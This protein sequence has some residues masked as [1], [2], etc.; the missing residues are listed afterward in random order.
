[1]KSWLKYILTLCVL[2][3]A[4]SGARASTNDISTVFHSYRNAL[5]GTN[6]VAAWEAVDFHTQKYYEQILKDAISLP[7]ADFDRLHIVSK[8]TIVRLRAEYRK[9]HLKTMTGKDFFVD[10]VNK[11]WISKSSVQRIENLV[12]IK[13][14]QNKA[15]ASVPE[16]PNLPLFFFIKEKEGWKLSLTQTFDLAIEAMNTTIKNSGLT[17]NE[18][19]LTMTRR[20]SKFQVPDSV[21]DGPTE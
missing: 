14:D 17:E 1:M 8:F 10:A 11:G 6:G 7:R 4:L 18:F 20:V 5:L 19:I 12:N 15:S 16:Q 9:G 13:I 21:L 3:A 2:L